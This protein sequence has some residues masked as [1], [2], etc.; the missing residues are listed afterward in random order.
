[1]FIF[2]VAVTAPVPTELL[3][4]L[5]ELLKEEL[6]RLELEEL[7]K[8]ELAREEEELLGTEELLLNE[9]DELELLAAPFSITK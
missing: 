5:E 4:E 9:L 3:L 8:D 6:L 7:L 1:M 2:T